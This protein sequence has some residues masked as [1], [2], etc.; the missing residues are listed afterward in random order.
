[1]SIADKLQTVA[2]NQ[3]KVF[4]AGKK[5]EYDA[6]WDIFQR[7]GTR[8]NYSGAFYGECWTEINFKPK[9]DI[10]PTTAMNIFRE[11]IINDD[12][13]K[14]LNELGIVYDTSNAKSFSYD[15]YASRFTRLPEIDLRNAI[16]NVAI[17]SGCKAEEIRIKT[18][19]TTP[20]S[21]T[22]QKCENLVTLSVE[23]II[24]QNG[25][26]LQWSTLL[27]HDSLMSIINSLYDYSTDTSGQTYTITLGTENL[28]KL[29]AEE[30]T[31][32][33]NKGWNY[34]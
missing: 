9:Y 11:T 29:T 24:G 23:G 27:S 1:M 14:I 32:I 26:N 13:Q 4:E 10:K 20:Y 21:N 33:E 17:F 22:F 19:K 12:L 2:E 15:F 18:S 6:F 16:T 28:A 7:N 3:E 8:T 5:S 31:M 30:I 34:G 25:V